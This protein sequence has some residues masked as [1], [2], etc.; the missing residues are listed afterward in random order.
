MKCAELRN[1]IQSSGKNVKG[2]WKMKKEE[3]MIEYAKIM[4]V[5]KKVD[6]NRLHN[7]PEDLQ[8]MIMN[9]SKVK[10]IAASNLVYYK[11]K[12][13]WTDSFITINQ[14]ML[15]KLMN[16]DGE[17]S[18]REMLDTETSA[19]GNYNW[20]LTL[21]NNENLDTSVADD[22]SE[23]AVK[24]NANWAQLLLD[25]V[26]KDMDFNDVERYIDEIGWRKALKMANE[27]DWGMEGWDIAELYEERGVRRILWGVMYELLD[28]C[29]TYEECDEEE[30]KRI[31]DL[32]SD[33]RDDNEDD[34][35]SVE[36]E[37]NEE[38]DS[39]IWDGYEAD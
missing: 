31:Y 10:D 1:A 16:D 8:K 28:I 6:D 24:V 25:E 37:D 5:K 34:E 20:L 9:M 21:A 14:D 39:V 3:L 32:D 22:K 15:D 23:C 12:H 18:F 4:D 33:N 30:Y 29:K 27:S 17:S 2:I 36:E 7:L 26:I 13:Q 35:S 11:A 19:I 38:D